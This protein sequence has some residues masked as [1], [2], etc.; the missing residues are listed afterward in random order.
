[1][2]TRITGKIGK[3]SS[4]LFYVKV[5]DVEYTGWRAALLLLLFLPIVAP[6]IALGA[7][8]WI[9]LSIVRLI[10]KQDR[11]LGFDYEDGTWTYRN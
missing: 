2:S 9:V 7:L 6:F 10:T 11:V 8:L 1:M 5:N 4:P 3:Q